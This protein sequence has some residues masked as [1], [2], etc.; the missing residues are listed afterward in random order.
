MTSPQNRMKVFLFGSGAFPQP[1][2][3]EISA[4]TWSLN[5]LSKG[6]ALYSALEYFSF[7]CFLFSPLHCGCV[8]STLS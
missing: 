5:A 6:A 7:F 8:S 1:L 3:T 4:Q 2:N